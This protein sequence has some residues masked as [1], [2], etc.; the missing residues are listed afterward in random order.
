MYYIKRGKQSKAFLKCLQKA[1]LKGRLPKKYLFRCFKIKTGAAFRLIKDELCDAFYIVRTISA[2]AMVLVFVGLATTALGL[3]LCVMK[4]KV[5]GLQTEK[6]QLVQELTQTKTELEKDIEALTNS[7]ESNQ[8][9]S[10]SKD[11]IIEEQKNALANSETEKEEIIKNFTEQIDNLDL[12]GSA[13]S[14]SS[15]ELSSADNS[16]SQIELLI[17]DTLGYTETANTLIERLDV[18]REALQDAADRYPDYFPTIG[19]LGSPF[20]YR[21]D[22]IT[23]ETRYHS[24]QDIGSGTGTP[25]WA[26]GKGTVSYVGYED[27]YGYHICIDHGNGLCTKYA[28]L[29]EMLV[30]VGD[31]I[32]KGDLVAYMG[33]TGRV[34]GPHLHFEV[35]KDGERVDPAGYI[36]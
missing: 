26:A 30:S 34:T 8:E 22:P 19:E 24:G 35:I 18:K 23:G 7:L 32:K 29:S 33:G 9:E 11:K 6:T 4:V 10:Q 36:G 1:A 21:R 5:A 16:F 15:A 14:R 17:R 28:H 27:G 2:S 3:N 12:I 25:I 20:G 31:E 13:T